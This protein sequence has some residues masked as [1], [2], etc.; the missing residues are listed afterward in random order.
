MS[1]H[2]LELNK[3]KPQGWICRFCNGYNDI[4]TPY[5]RYCQAYLGVAYEGLLARV[6]IQRLGGYYQMNTAGK[7]E[8]ELFK[9]FFD[10]EE[11]VIANMDWQA[12]ESHIEDLELIVYEGRVR[13]QKATGERRARKEKLSKEDR[14]KL[15]SNPDYKSD[16]DSLKPAPREKISRADKLYADMTKLFGGNSDLAKSMILD[17]LKPEPEAAKIP[18]VF[19]KEFKATPLED[20]AEIVGIRGDKDSQR[21]ALMEDLG[22]TLA[23]RLKLD[24]GSDAYDSARQVAHM[25]RALNPE[26]KIEE[27]P[28]EQ[29]VIEKTKMDIEPEGLKAAE[30]WLN[31]FGK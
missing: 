14:E 10:S 30:D 21:L 25:A 4:C 8:E 24:A 20:K 28:F 15:I 29:I 18:E 7:K 9:E 11:R 12:L 1:N 5:C 3:G 13:L 27:I 26:L 23:G 17:N 22:N 19:K 16:R 2:R 6:K 31:I